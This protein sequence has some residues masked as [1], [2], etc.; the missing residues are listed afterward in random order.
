M[1]SHLRLADIIKAKTIPEGRIPMKPFDISTLV[2]KSTIDLQ[3]NT[4]AQPELL[5][6]YD[7]VIV[8]QGPTSKNK[9]RRRNP[10]QSDFIL[11]C[12]TK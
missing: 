1:K 11:G 5:K 3:L 12:F 9:Y 7:H 2:Q 4:E 6:D 8:L 10:S